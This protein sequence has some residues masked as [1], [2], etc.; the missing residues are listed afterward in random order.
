MSDPSR[1]P[2]ARALASLCVTLTLFGA[3]IM[4]RATL[5]ALASEERGLVDRAIEWNL[6]ITGAV[7]VGAHLAL[8]ASLVRA[9]RRPVPESARLE[10]S[11]TVGTGIVL[12][13]LLLLAETDIRALATLRDA[14]EEPLEVEVVGQQFAWNFRL[15]GEDGL[16]GKTD[17][18]LQD[19]FEMNFIGLDRSDPAAEDDVVFPQG[20]LVVPR[21]RPV[22]LRIRSMDVIH[23]FFVPALR[24]KRDAVPGI[25]TTLVF[26]ASADGEFE[27]A[28][29]EH[30]GLGHYRMRAVLSVVDPAAFAA[31]VREA[32]Q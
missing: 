23:G 15:A 5:P 28:C 25:E 3:W 22:R 20:I 11:W 2:I 14:T 8:A 26:R 32:T 29:A 19:Q 27:V 24:I 1:P 12:V 30:C 31:R 10:A 9:R 6:W 13:A 4:A 18:R 17:P 7:F 16:F 21:D